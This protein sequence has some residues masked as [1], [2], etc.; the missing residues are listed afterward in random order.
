M[1]SY[2]LS[3]NQKEIIDSFSIVE[4]YELYVNFKNQEGFSYNKGTEKEPKMQEDYI[5]FYK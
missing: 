5:Y 3:K 2:L 1:I 4:Q